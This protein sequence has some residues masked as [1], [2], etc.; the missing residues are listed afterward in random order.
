MHKYLILALCILALGCGKSSV[1]YTKF[2]GER[3]YEELKTQ[4]NMP[5]RIPGTE[6]HKQIQEYIRKKLKE[7]EWTVES[8]QFN[9]YYQQLKKKLPMS[10]IWGK[11][12]NDKT[13]NYIL[14]GAHYD[15]RAFADKDKESPDQPLPAANDGASGVAVLFEL[16]KTLKDHHSLKGKTGVML[17]FIDGEDGGRTSSY[18]CIGSKY[19]VS[20][21][22]DLKKIKQTII[23]DMIGDKDL[24]VYMDKFA[25]EAFKKENEA[26]FS[27]ANKLYPE[28]FKKRVKYGMTDDHIPFIKK[29]IPAIELIDFDYPP[30]HTL[31]DTPDKCS[32][33]SLKAVGD[34]LI[35]YLKSQGVVE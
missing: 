32:A 29:D 6:G 34:V 26:F 12:D 14:I 2:D 19:F 35:E 28:K 3:A 23:I 5:P 10:N 27:L 11:M 9:G 31:E 22:S 33:E 1:S 13:E 7:S 20:K 8:D 21:Y 25:T 4:C 30:F 18:Y 15:S 16:A 17:L 24:T